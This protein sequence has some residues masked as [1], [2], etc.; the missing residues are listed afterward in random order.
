MEKIVC[1]NCGK[2]VPSYEYKCPDCG[3][4]LRERVFNIDLWN[5]IWKLFY[6]PVEAFRKIVFAEHKNYT[7]IFSILLGVKFF[8]TVDLTTLLFK[9]R[10]GESPDLLKNLI[11]FSVLFVFVLIL[12]SLLFKIVGQIFKEKLRFKDFYSILIFSFSPLIFVLFIIFPFEY[13]LF[14]NYW[15]TF[16]PSPFI[17]RPVAAYLLISVEG[18]LTF[19][20]FLNLIIGLSYYFSSKIKGIIAG[21]ILI[22]TLFYLTVSFPFVL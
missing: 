8:L 15:F 10:N 12:F 16:N 20:S 13:A 1:P 9:L 22:A 2:E 5:T 18:L 11:L 21:V 4:F 19:W 7:I 17:L 14:G 3:N 6:S